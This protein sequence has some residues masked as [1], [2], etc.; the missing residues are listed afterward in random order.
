MESIGVLEGGH[1]SLQGQ[2][3]SNSASVSALQKELSDLGSVLNDQVGRRELCI[4]N[5]S[6]DIKLRLCRP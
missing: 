1:K 6:I 3:G 5:V 2:V 4:L